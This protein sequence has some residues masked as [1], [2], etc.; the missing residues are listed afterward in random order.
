MKGALRRFKETVD[1]RSSVVNRV[2]SHPY[3]PSAA[4]FAV[5]VVVSCVHIW[6][7]VVVLE[8]VKEVAALNSENAALVDDARKLHARI[9]SL[10]LSERIR[11]YAVDSLHM[12]PV[13]AEHL[14]TLIRK[15]DAAP[16]LDDFDA[17][18]TAFKRLAVHLPTVVGTEAK[19]GEIDVIMF[20]SC[21]GRGARR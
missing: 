16:P 7:R 13:A 5:I 20:D 15:R 17:M 21:A 11:N 6:Q 8:M 2:R 14:Y 1:I 9:A 3:L 4:L 10:S 19:A 12:Q 18:L